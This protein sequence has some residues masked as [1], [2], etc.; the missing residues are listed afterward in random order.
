[1]GMPCYMNLDESGLIND[2]MIDWLFETEHHL[3]CDEL[4]TYFH[5]F[6]KNNPYHKDFNGD[7]EVA[8]ALVDC[9]MY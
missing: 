3:T 7:W 4:W 2:A 5:T 8:Y 6:P 9:S 1:M